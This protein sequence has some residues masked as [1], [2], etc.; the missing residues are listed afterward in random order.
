MQRRAHS[1]CHMRSDLPDVCMR[2]KIC[3]AIL[4][5]WDLGEQT[6]VLLA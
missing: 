5:S 3:D 2:G 4:Q 1:T 6:G